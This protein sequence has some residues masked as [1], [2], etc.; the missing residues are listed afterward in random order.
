[1]IAV[2]D[3]ASLILRELLKGPKR[4]WGIRELAGKVGG[5][6]GYVSRMA[7]IDVPRKVQYALSVQADAEG[8]IQIVQIVEQRPTD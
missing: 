6:P 1:M 5:N 8:P 3:K 7:K 2:S 4:Q